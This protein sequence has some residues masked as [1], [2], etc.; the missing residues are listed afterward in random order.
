[1]RRVSRMPSCGAND[2]SRALAQ[3]G[4]LAAMKRAAASA[5]R[6][7]SRSPSDSAKGSLASMASRVTLN[8]PSSPPGTRLQCNAARGNAP[9]ATPRAASAALVSALMPSKAAKSIG[10]RRNI[11]VAGC[12]LSPSSR[13]RNGAPARAIRSRSPELSMNNRARTSSRP[14]LVSTRRRADGAAAARDLGELAV[15]QHP[16]ARLVDHLVEHDL[17]D[18]GV[19]FD[20]VHAMAGRHDEMAVAAAAAHRLQAL[21]DLLG[22]ARDHA[23]AGPCLPADELA[24]RARG[25]RAAQ[26]AMALE[27]QGAR[28]L[29]G[30]G[31]GGHGSRHSAAAGQNVAIDGIHFGNRPYS[32]T[33]EEREASVVSESHDAPRRAGRHGRRCRLRRRR[34]PRSSPRRRSHC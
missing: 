30:G 22:D 9:S 28:A 26:E 2:T 6:R 20:T 27:Q 12:R 18:L 3:P 7:P 17:Q 34:A 32:R 11:M 24:D 4:T 5:W 1:M 15:Q 25:R 10:P 14:P 13:P 19:V 16:H 23:P 21:D 31:D 29:A 33:K 8:Q